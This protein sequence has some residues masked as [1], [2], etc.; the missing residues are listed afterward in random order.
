MDGIDAALLVTDG[1]S[2][3]QT[4]AYHGLG[5]DPSFKHLLHA[6]QYHIRL[7]RGDLNKACS[8]F[9]NQGFHNYLRTE[10]GLSVDE[11]NTQHQNC[12]KY[13]QHNKLQLTDVIRK[14]TELH[15][16]AVSTL[17]Q[18][19]EYQASEITAIG[20]HGQTMYHQPNAATSVI[21]GDG[22]YLAKLTNIAVINDFRTNDIRLGGQGAPFA[23]IYHQALVKR[24]Q[25]IPAVIVNCGGIANITL[26]QDDDPER[27]IGFDTGP[28]NGD[29]KSVV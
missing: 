6:A 20:Y 15:A 8:D 16:Q 1:D 11:I 5:Y 25:K 28:G 27:L 26:I 7:H 22:Q 3:I 4:I 13:M 10:L 18:K 17:L 12:L 9:D 24:D 21:V 29:R 14:S 23:P 2:H 19:S